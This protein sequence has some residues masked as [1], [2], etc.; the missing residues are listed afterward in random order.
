MNPVLL[1]KKKGREKARAGPKRT[2]KDIH[3]K[4][5]SNTVAKFLKKLA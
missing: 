1:L 2:E 5:G 3:R 4:G